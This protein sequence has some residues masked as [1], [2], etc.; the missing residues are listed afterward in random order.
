MSERIPSAAVEIAA[1][2]SAFRPPSLAARRIVTAVNEHRPDEPQHEPWDDA[3]DAAAEYFGWTEERRQSEKTG[4]ADRRARGDLD[5]SLEGDAEVL[6]R[7]AALDDEAA[8][9]PRAD[10]PPPA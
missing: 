9:R 8:D 2:L 7:F 4:E 3:V 10:D 1:N 6:R 5:R